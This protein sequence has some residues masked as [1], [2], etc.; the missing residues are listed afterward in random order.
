MK[1]ANPGKTVSLPVGN[2]FAG[3][4]L[5]ILVGT[6]WVMVIVRLPEG[7]PRRREGVVRRGCLR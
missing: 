7:I 4:G 1:E 5:I 3:S 2:L 6:A